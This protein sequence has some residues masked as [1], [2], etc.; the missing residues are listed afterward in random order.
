MD[1]V[2]A[3]NPLCAALL[4]FAPIYDI[5]F[6]CLSL[7]SLVQVALTCHAA[8]K[9][10]AAYKTR[11]FN[12]N[13][14]FSRYFTDPIAFRSLQARTNTLIS[15]SNVLQ[16][17]DKTF[18]PEADLD[19]YTH[20]GHSFEVA[21]FLV[22]EGYR[23]A[24]RESQEQ[25]WKEAIKYNWDGTQRRAIPQ[26]GTDRVYPRR[27]IRA[28]WTFEKTGKDEERLTVQIVEASSSPVES[29]LGFHSSASSSVLILR[30]FVD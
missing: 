7:R 8:R 3:H 4:A 2:N 14:H 11:A 27:E 21:Q 22:A 9:A 24:P 19:L 23:Y 1:T 16:F 28:V 10:V 13:R 25:D 26:E 15:G 17:L 18:Y 6:S 20:P 30:L 5:V 29:I 12:V